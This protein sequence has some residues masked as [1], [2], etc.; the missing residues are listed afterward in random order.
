MEECA[1]AAPA[2]R[3]E[4]AD[5]RL[6]EDRPMDNLPVQGV[7]SH[8]LLEGGSMGRILAL[9]YGVVCY[10]VF[11]GT[12]LYLIWFVWSMS[13]TRPEA[14]LDRALLIDGG[15]VLPVRSPAQCDGAAVVQE[16]VDQDCLAAGRAQH[17]CP[18]CEFS[19]AG[20]DLF[21]AA[22]AFG[23]LGGEPSPRPLAAARSVRC[24]LACGSSV[25]LPDRPLRVVR[26][27]AGL[28]LLAAATLSASRFQ[29][30][31]VLSLRSPSH[32]SRVPH[33]PLVHTG[34]D[35]RPLVLRPDDHGLH[36]DRHPDGGARPHPF[37]RR[38][39]Q[40]LPQWRLY[41]RAV[42][43]QTETALGVRKGF[44]SI[45]PDES[46]PSRSGRCLL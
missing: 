10:F 23:H 5:S 15:L 41:A 16:C 1:Q 3:P 11:F 26:V 12:F 40:G 25:H 7:E 31:S 43:E 34:D 22:G 17:L 35:R 2:P 6:T 13:P 37:P 44:R 8:G 9:L 32:L 45:P 19:V 36:P 29:D 14:P 4:P 46:R 27:E 21:L 24:G 39:L 42:A 30:A 28:E 33:N 38:G 18:D 20:S